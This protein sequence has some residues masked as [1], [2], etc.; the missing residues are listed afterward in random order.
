MTPD[1]RLRFFTDQVMGRMSTGGVSFAQEDG[2]P[3]VRMTGRVRTANRGGF[4]QMWTGLPAPPP[5]GATGVPPL[6]LPCHGSAYGVA[7]H[8]LGMPPPRK[9]P[10]C[11]GSDRARGG[12][13][14][15]C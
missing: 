4:I 9:A 3:H 6:A 15:V 11:R 2:M 12:A 10:G 1:A 13:E 5:E 7:G 14:C 8:C